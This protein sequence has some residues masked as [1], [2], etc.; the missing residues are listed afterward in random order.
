MAKMSYEGPES[1]AHDKNNLVT[2]VVFCRIPQIRAENVGAPREKHI[3][4]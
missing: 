3:D 1:C 4:K 2:K